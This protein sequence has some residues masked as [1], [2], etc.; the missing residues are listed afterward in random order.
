MGKYGS[1]PSTSAH[2]ILIVML[3]YNSHK[4]NLSRAKCEDLSFCMPVVEGKCVHT[5]FIKKTSDVECE[6]L[7]LCLLVVKRKY[8]HTISK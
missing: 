7:S 6:G 8:N 4:E 3:P 2:S 5:M 1:F